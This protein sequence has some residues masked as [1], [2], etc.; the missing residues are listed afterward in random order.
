ML[1]Q[2]AKGYLP[3]DNDALYADVARTMLQTGDWLNPNI[4][5][6]PFLDKPPLFFWL[7]AISVSVFGETIFAF[8]LPATVFGA[9]SV[10]LVF[11]IVRT[12]GGSRL[13]AGVAALSLL[14]IPIFFEYTRRAYMEVPVAFCVLASVS[15]FHRGIQQERSAGF[16][17]AG[18][19]TGLG[20]MFKS[21]V[22]LFGAIG[23]VVFVLIT[24]RWRLVMSR[25][26]WAGA[27]VALTI[28]LPWHIDQLANNTTAFLEFTYK[29]HIEDQVLTAQPWSSGPAW[30]YLET[31]A[32]QTPWL[33]ILFVVALAGTV[34]NLQ[35]RSSSTLQNLLLTVIVATVFVFSASATKKNLY[36]VAFIPCV[37]TLLGLCFDSI[38]KKRSYRIFACVI[39]L[40]L[41]ARCLPFLDSDGVFLRGGESYAVASEA[42]NVLDANKSKPVYLLDQYFSA[43]QFYTKRRAISVW[44]R[45]KIV[46]QTQRIPYIRYGDNMRYTPQSNL[47]STILH[48]EEAFWFLPE[49][50]VSALVPMQ[51]PSIL[52]NQNGLIILDSG[53]LNIR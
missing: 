4:H 35:Q 29:L 51:H 9:L 17:W 18:F 44:T 47:R 34:F 37:V 2:L 52:Y 41:A 32:T 14:S 22:G 49:A 19:W 21:V 42:I 31:L 11:W 30:F 23:F 40:L 16:L 1:V 25:K 45:E 36:M 13:A 3:F 7:E 53:L 24:R 20:F 10:G 50:L 26:L 33:G 5:G 46:N 27:A 48:N 28:L 43:A 12:A 38:F 39:P 15:A 6:V 8:R